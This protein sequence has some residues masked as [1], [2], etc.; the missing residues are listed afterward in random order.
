MY[1]RTPLYLDL[2][3]VEICKALKATDSKQSSGPDNLDPYRLKLA[4]DFITE[5]IAQSFPIS[6]SDK[7][8]S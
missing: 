6:S 3:S 7:Y 8:H 4:A 2:S 5:P 1:L